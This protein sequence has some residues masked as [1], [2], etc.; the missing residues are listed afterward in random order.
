MSL[1]DNDKKQAWAHI[2]NANSLLGVIIGLG[3]GFLVGSEKYM[4]MREKMEAGR[5]KE[6]RDI[7][8]QAFEWLDEHFAALDLTMDA[9]AEQ[10]GT[11][12]PVSFSTR[13]SYVKLWK[14]A[15]LS[16]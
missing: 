15:R 3:Q 9:A 7:R 14:K 6:N 2:C 11:I 16:R 13:R 10:L 4:T 8:D 1:K 12:V 5:H